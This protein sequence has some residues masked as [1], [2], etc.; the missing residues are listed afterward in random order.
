VRI[1]PV[2]LQNIPFYGILD[3]GYV[4]HEEWESKCRAL[5]EGGAGMIQIRAKKETPDQRRK[6]LDQILHLFQDVDIPL[7]IND[8]VELAVSY[9]GLGLH[10]GQEDLAPRIARD[11]LG[12]DRIIGLSTHSLIQAQAAICQMELINYFAVGP[13]FATG[14]KPDY[15]PVGLQLISQVKKLEPQLPFFCI[16]GI[17]RSNL[18]QVRAAGASGVVAVSDVLLDKDTAQAVCQFL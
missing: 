12:P 15:T 1:L 5:I 13:I 4:S 17:N 18:A 7:I 9:P 10:V 2:E 6:L 3:T 14:T 16:G 8:D 11:R